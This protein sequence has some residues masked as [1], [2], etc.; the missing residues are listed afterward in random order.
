MGIDWLA[1]VVLGVAYAFSRVTSV[2]LALRNWVFAAACFGIAG[3]RLARGGGNLI[4][5]AIAAGIGVTYV[6]QAIRAS[7]QGS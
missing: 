4:F 6:V 2:S 7:K 3:Y 5:V 1:V